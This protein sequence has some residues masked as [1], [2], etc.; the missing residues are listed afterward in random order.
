M[1]EN[2]SDEELDEKVVGK[3]SSGFDKIIERDENDSDETP[4]SEREKSDENW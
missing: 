4:I 1:G 2:V 3:N